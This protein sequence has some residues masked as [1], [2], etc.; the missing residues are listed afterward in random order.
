MEKRMHSQ[1]YHFSV[2][3]FFCFLFSSFFSSLLSKLL[4]SV[5]TPTCH[6]PQPS[7][8]PFWVSKSHQLPVWMFNY[9]SSNPVV[10]KHTRVTAPRQ[11][12]FPSSNKHR[13]RGSHE[14]LPD[15]GWQQLHL[16]RSCETQAYYHEAFYQSN[17]VAKHTYTILHLAPWK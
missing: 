9:F 4:T 2:S 14:I 16:M 10:P 7:P 12:L 3:V 6:H 11:L 1:S 17:S 15:P 5:A 13:P 8:M